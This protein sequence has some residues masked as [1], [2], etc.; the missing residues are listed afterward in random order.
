MERSK[1]REKR[2]GRGAL[3]RTEWAEQFRDKKKVG[4]FVGLKD[5]LDDGWTVFGQ[6]L[7]FKVF[8]YVFFLLASLIKRPTCS[9][10]VWFMSVLP[11]KRVNQTNLG[12]K[13]VYKSFEVRCKACAGVSSS[14]KSN[15]KLNGDFF[16]FPFNTHTH[17]HLVCPAAPLWLA[18]LLIQFAPLPLR[19]WVSACQ[20]YGNKALVSQNMTRVLSPL[21]QVLLPNYRLLSR[22]LHRENTQKQREHKQSPMKKAPQISRPFSGGWKLGD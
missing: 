14:V 11:C 2:W 12:L 3:L 10:C 19:S 16:F 18:K 22:P 8:D 13:K 1:K 6:F 9:V 20:I 15:D 7:L 5:T 4:V 17:T 21:V